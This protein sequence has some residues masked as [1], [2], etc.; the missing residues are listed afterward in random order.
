MGKQAGWM[1]KVRD[2]FQPEIAD[3]RIPRG[4]EDQDENG[5]WKLDHTQFTKYIDKPSA[6]IDL[7]ELRTRAES[8][9]ANKTDFMMASLKAVKMIEMSPRSKAMDGLKIALFRAFNHGDPRQ[10]QAYENVVVK[11]H[12]SINGISPV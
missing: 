7:K 4:S 10:R 3:T 8:I 6:D 2:A 1:D 11:W 9:S 5:K 12:K